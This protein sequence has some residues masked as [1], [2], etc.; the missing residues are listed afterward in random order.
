MSQL[1]LNIP[2][3]DNY[4]NNCISP[5]YQG[6]KN[7]LYW[8]DS[9][10]YFCKKR[11]IGS[12]NYYRESL[13]REENI[14][15]YLKNKIYSNNISP[16]SKAVKEEDGEIVI[17]Q[18]SFDSGDL[19]DYCMKGNCNFDTATNFLSSIKNILISLDNLKIIYGDFCLENFMVTS[20]NKFNLVDF[21]CSEVFLEEKEYEWNLKKYLLIRPYYIS[22]D[23][24]ENYTESKI[25]DRE[26]IYSI[27]QKKEMF[28]IG[29]VLHSIV[30]GNNLW[31]CN[32]I[33][34]P[35]VKIRRLQ[36]L[37]KNLNNFITNN[38]NRKE[39]LL[40]KII[41][42]LLPISINDMISLKQL[43][44]DINELEGDK[45]RKFNL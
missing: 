43:V 44:K 7:M 27:L 8:I 3:A 13:E 34:P 35:D 42:K 6:N 25:M 45:K 21:G 37:R 12:P 1:S 23:L 5:V 38:N 20:D 31:K 17:M 9:D 16:P 18:P 29:L 19:F 41:L 2:E 22:P 40:Y 26:T 15:N 30:F 4:P 11:K 28:T 39:S 36:Y 24:Q 10:G 33:N 14:S 32:Y